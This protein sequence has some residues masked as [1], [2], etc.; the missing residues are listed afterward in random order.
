MTDLFLCALR[1]FDTLLAARGRT[2]GF[3]DYTLKRK[4]NVNGTGGWCD[5]LAW[6]GGADLVRRVPFGLNSVVIVCSVSM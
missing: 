1:H 2:F 4:A 6:R 3:G 5:R